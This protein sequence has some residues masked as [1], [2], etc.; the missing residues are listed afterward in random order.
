MCLVPIHPYQRLGPVPCHSEEVHV[1]RACGSAHLLVDRELWDGERAVGGREEAVVRE[2][3]PSARQTSQGAIKVSEENL[4][5]W[6]R[7]GEG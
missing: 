7:G 6:R 5:E 3:P 1:S 2:S 4:R